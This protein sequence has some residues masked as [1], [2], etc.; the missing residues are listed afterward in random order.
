MKI[1]QKPS[2][3]HDER[4]RPISLLLLHYTGMES[5]E[6]AIAKLCA[7]SSKVSAHYLV[8]ESGEIVALV[9]EERR[10][11]HAGESFWK[12]EKDINSASIGIEIANGGHD[13]GLPDFEEPQMLALFDLCRDLC[14]RHKILPQHV[15]GHSDVAPRRKQDPGEKFPWARFAEGGVGLWVSPHPPSPPLWG[16]GHEGAEV[17]ALQSKLINLG[18]GLVASG[19][20]DEDTSLILLAFQRHFRPQRI[21]GLADASTLQLLEK[22]LAIH[23]APS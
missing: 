19:V 20:H 12:G 8:K 7:P 16:E 22:L 9:P 4:A 6:A 15:L 23:A 10:A 21:D 11:W 1:L 18:Y 13:F 3:N 14:A 2:P 5:A 17:Q